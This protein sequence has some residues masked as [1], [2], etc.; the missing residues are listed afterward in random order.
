MCS[1]SRSSWNEQKDR[2][3]KPIGELSWPAAYTGTAA[4]VTRC[5]A[6]SPAEGF[7]RG[8]AHLIPRRL[9]PRC[10]QLRTQ[11]SD[12]LAELIVLASGCR[13]CDYAAEVGSPPVV[14]MQSAH[15]WVRTT[16]PRSKVNM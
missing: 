1:L 13:I 6:G 5:P 12:Q 4:A 2:H 16:V 3:G 9:G 14:P 7:W 15:G 10:S 11:P 8:D